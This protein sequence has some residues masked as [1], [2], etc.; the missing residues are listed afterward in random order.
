MDKA[1]AIHDLW[2]SFGL[3]A[4]DQNTVPENAQMP[5]ITYEVA[6]GKMDDVLLLT[7]SLW[8]HSLSWAEISRKAEE[9]AEAI[10]GSGYYLHAVDGGYLWV[11]QGNPF[12]QRVQDEDDTVRRILINL[13]V[14]FLTAY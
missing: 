7:G 14:E 4:Y 13:N 3:E 12:S 10:G 9:I 1:Q 11:T 8:Y 2:S 6:T 5:Y